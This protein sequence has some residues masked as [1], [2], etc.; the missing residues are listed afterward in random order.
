MGLN[1]ALFVL[2]DLGSRL[3]FTRFG[4]EPIDLLPFPVSLVAG[5]YL[6]LILLSLCIRPT[7]YLPGTIALTAI[8]ARCWGG[9]LIP[10]ADKFHAR[11]MNE[12]L[13]A[14]ML[15]RFVIQ[16]LPCTLPLSRHLIHQLL[17]I[18]TLDNK[19]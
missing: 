6:G 11:L 17:S 1:L 4:F 2:G 15:I 8:T 9:V 18:P 13:L 3:L 10:I 14:F 5:L 7:G 19:R 12:R 16:L